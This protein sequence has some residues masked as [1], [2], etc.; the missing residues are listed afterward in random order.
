MGEFVASIGMRV[1]LLHLRCQLGV[2]HGNDIAISRI[3]ASRTGL[4]KHAFRK[5]GVF[6]LCVELR[7]NDGAGLLENSLHLL[8]FFRAKRLAFDLLEE[9]NNFRRELVQHGAGV[10][11]RSF[12]KPGVGLGLRVG[13]ERNFLKHHGAILNGA[14]AFVWSRN[15]VGGLI[16][17]FWSRND[18]HISSANRGRESFRWSVNVLLLAVLAGGCTPL[19]A[20]LVR[21]VCQRVLLDDVG[22]LGIKA[23]N[24][25]WSV[26]D[27]R[28]LKRGMRLPERGKRGSNPLALGFA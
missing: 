11:L 19:T 15:E 18:N 5:L 10:A 20:S 27:G 1:K 12:T 24:G 26:L 14:A 8:G 22:G 4:N 16:P 21:A 3:L 9:R 2:I 7:K 23:C 25:L 28:G 13:D 17:A 6:D